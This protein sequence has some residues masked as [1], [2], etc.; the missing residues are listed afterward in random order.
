MIKL[1]VSEVIAGKVVT[2]VGQIGDSLSV[3][4]TT[5]GSDDETLYVVDKK[6]TLITK[7]HIEA[8]MSQGCR[9]VSNIVFTQ[10]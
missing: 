8:D 7:I 2:K 9:Y 1:Q 4:K 10:H 3:Y 5:E 6:N